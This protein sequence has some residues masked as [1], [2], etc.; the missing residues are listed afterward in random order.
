[1]EG[2]LERFLA[3]DGSRAFLDRLAALYASMDEA[4]ERVAGLYGFGCGGCGENCCSQRFH[5]HTL[6]EYFYLFEGMKL[7]GEG[8]ARAIIEKAREVTASYRAEAETGAVLPLMCPAN[9]DGLCGLYGH[10][11]MICRLHGLPYEFRRPDGAASAG[12]GCH[13]FAALN[14]GAVEKVDRT[15]HYTGLALLERQVRE[16]L[17]FGGRYKKTTA[18]M[19]V[20]MAGALA[21]EGA[22]P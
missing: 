15:G 2:L 22:G 5:H 1:M 21:L 20:D 11:P 14:P 19:L 13:R 9:F 7:A 16:R 3:M 17:G 8:R 12:G 4:Y 6:M 18:R 10:R